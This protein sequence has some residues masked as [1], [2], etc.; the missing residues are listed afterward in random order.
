M[1]SLPEFNTQFSSLAAPFALAALLSLCALSLFSFQ[2]NRFNRFNKA[3]ENPGTVS[4]LTTQKEQATA[5]SNA[6][7]ERNST[8]V[9]GASEISLC[10]AAF[11]PAHTIKHGTT[12]LPQLE[13]KI[14][15]KQR[16]RPSVQLFFFQSS[17][18]RHLCDFGYFSLY[19]TLVLLAP[20]NTNL[21]NI[22]TRANTDT[23]SPSTE[24]DPQPCARALL[25]LHK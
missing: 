13:S 24:V 11:T 3:S 9:T 14:R 17:N 2:L 25:R 19:S 16:P 6:V 15:Q 10:H 12:R 22:I 18:D 7:E 5:T 8:Q 20:S 4:H 1:P 21:K 23:Q